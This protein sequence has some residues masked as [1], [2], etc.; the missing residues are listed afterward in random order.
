M[1][2][3][4]NLDSGEHH[5]SHTASALFSTKYEGLLSRDDNADHL[6]PESIISPHIYSYSSI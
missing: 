2:K 1:G 4:H 6:T 5:T 3:P